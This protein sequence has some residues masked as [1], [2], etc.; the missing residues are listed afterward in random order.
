MHESVYLKKKEWF[1]EI[2]LPGTRRNKLDGF[3]IDK[4]IYDGK[5]QFQH[6]RIF[7]SLGFGRILA[8]DD[9]IQFSEIDEFIYHETI[10]HVPLL[11]HPRPKHLLVVGGGDG[12]VLR[13]AA[14]HPLERLYHV[15][16][17][18]QIVEISKKY[19]PSVS[20][21]VFLDKRLEHHFEDGKN[22]VK[23]FTDFFDAIIVDSTD[24]LGPGKV[25]FSLS[26]YRSVFNALKMDGLAVFQV[27][28]FLDFNLLVRPYAR[29]LKKL[30]PHV[31]CIRV[32]MPSYSCGS[33][34]CFLIASKK[35]NPKTITRS[36]IAKRL[37]KRLGRKAE[38]L[39]YYT[40][41]IHSASMV[42]PKLWQLTP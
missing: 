4:Q 12:G 11:T 20:N 15:E 8:L 37:T 27:G 22:F 10:A 1:L 9:V 17:D 31:A 13:E 3:R 26:F 34:Y 16:L 36:T 35:V 29:K 24:P 23:K 38:Q 40:P 30:F 19:L 42:M 18:S 28:P 14:K 39:K 32:P 6:I 25:L 41:E 21:G 5:S 33:E 2:P 7:E